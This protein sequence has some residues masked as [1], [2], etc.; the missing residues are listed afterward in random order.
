MNT[1]F[2]DF[3]RTLFDTNGLITLMQKYEPSVQMGTASF[4]S[5]LEH[6]VHNLHT[7]VFPDVKPTLD[8][9]RSN[10][11]RIVLMTTAEN[12]T[13]QEIKIHGSGIA[14][15][16]N[17]T[18]IVPGLKGEAIAE[19]LTKYDSAEDMHYFIDDVPTILIDAQKRNPRLITFRIERAALRPQHEADA[20][21][22]T[23]STIITTLDELLHN[24]PLE[25]SGN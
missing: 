17:D 19:W 12:P 8:T 24:I 2:L 11:Y 5:I 3:D 14:H 18:I 16:L 10:G 13:A 1:V 4:I 21:R 15:Y 20:L 7:L 22:D 25:T 6:E 9:L 23:K